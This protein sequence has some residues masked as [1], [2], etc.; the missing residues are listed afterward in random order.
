MTYY[1]VRITPISDQSQEEVRVDLSLEELMERYV[2]PYRKGLPL[3]ISGRS[4]AAGDIHRIRISK[5]EQDS[6]RLS[7][8]IRA[9]QRSSSVISIGGPSILWR[10]ANRAE[11]VSDEFITGPPGSEP[12]S[13]SKQLEDLR[14]PPESREVFVVHGRN[15]AARNALFEFLRAIDL[16]P[17]E[18]S[19][20][21][22]STGRASPHISEILDAAF[23]RAH[24]VVVLFTPDDEA[25]LKEEFLKPGD[26]PYESELTGQARPNVLFE[27]GMAMARDED[28][29][30]LIEIGSLRPFSD[31]AGRH[32]IRFDGSPQQRQALAKR[33]EIAGFAVNLN[34]SGW[35]EA[36]DFEAAL[37]HSVPEVSE[38]ADDA[39]DF[40]EN[41]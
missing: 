32:V 16:R 26:P 27:A 35:L 34:G 15:D 24:A 29:T 12:G 13:T 20:A 22:Q 3:I 14:P 10:V 36:G 33:L 25:R 2:V 19:E 5:S 39:I 9:E 23:S 4:I 31:I 11:D 1:H 28:R 37:N 6:K 30:V 7:E 38:S 18:W 17:L 21:V 41:L 8:V 40:I